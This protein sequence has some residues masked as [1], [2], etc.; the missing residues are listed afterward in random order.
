MKILYLHQYFNTPA[1]AGGTRSYEMGRRLV[2]WGH[3]VHMIT[4]D[5]DGRFP[6]DKIWHET[7][8]AG[9]H[10]HWTPVPY[11]NAMP[12]NERIKAFFAFSWRAARRAVALGGDIVFATSTPLTIAIPGVYAS[13]R[14]GIPMVFEVRD[15]W[16]EVPLALGALRNPVT[17]K[18]ARALERFAY[19]NSSKIVA[20]SPGMKDG[21]VKTGYPAEHVA[22][23]PNGS[24][25]EFFDFLSSVGEELRRKTPWLGDRKLVVYIGTLGKVNNVSYLVDVAV[26]MAKLDPKIAFLVIGDG[27]EKK[28]IKDKAINSGV[29]NDNFYMMDPIPKNEVP[30][31]MSAASVATSFVDQVKELEINSANKFFDTLAAGKPIA[32]NYGGWQADIIDKY[33]NG[34][35]LD[36]NDTFGAAKILFYFIN[37]ENQLL[38]A[39]MASKKV[40]RELFDRNMLAKQFES[41]LVQAKNVY[42][43]SKR[44]RIQ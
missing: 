5:R 44:E 17:I 33:R 12:Y 41:L 36:P 32:I 31:W 19:K 6:K 35:Q 26:E 4:T 25:V 1:M 37:N 40:A 18:T 34:C 22:V 42:L 14:L 2:A 10:V 21:I 20:L 3:E 11:G 29:F 39:S 15:L 43:N 24:D 30:K 8:E 28:Y 13:K 27:Q 23:I 9:I 7:E 16:P 38:A